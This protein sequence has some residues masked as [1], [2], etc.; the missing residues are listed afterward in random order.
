MDVYKC[1]QEFT[2]CLPS[3]DTLPAVLPSLVLSL[4]EIQ[5]QL[6]GCQMHRW[7]GAKNWMQYSASPVTTMAFPASVLKWPQKQSQSI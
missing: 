1:A 6:H 7:T 2:S 5:I 3:D 4:L